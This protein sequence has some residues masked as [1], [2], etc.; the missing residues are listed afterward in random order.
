MMVAV[1]PSS[2]N[3]TYNSLSLNR[4]FHELATAVLITVASR[5]MRTENKPSPRCF[6]LFLVCAFVGCCF[7]VLIKRVRL[8]TDFRFTVALTRRRVDVV[9]FT[10]R[11]A[12]MIRTL[13]SRACV[14]LITHAMTRP[15]FIAISRLNW[16][17]KE[18]IKNDFPEPMGF[19]D[20]R[21]ANEK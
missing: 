3:P 17:C 1:V 12:V 15:S 18:P 19:L 6:N 13:R 4:S 10:R 16:C 7:F 20:A 2:E 11:R 5:G 14:R 21:V 8:Q 9:C